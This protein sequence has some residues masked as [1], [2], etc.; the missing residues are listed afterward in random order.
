MHHFEPNYLW[1]Q[2]VSG[3]GDR[4]H[5]ISFAK[6]E[7]EKLRA[8]TTSVLARLKWDRVD[9][10][11]GE[12][13]LTPTISPPTLPT[14]SLVRWK[15]Y[16]VNYGQGVTSVSVSLYFYALVFSVIHC[17]LVFFF[18]VPL[19]GVQCSHFLSLC[20]NILYPFPLWCIVR[21][22]LLS[23]TLSLFLLPPCSSLQQPPKSWM[24]WHVSFHHPTVSE[25]RGECTD[26]RECVLR[27]KG[28][29]QP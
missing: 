9:N 25:D 8:R 2:L 26:Q 13:K 29:S 23:S 7:W 14:S 11:N 22:F 18:I 15:K 4:L 19:S 16:T 27:R 24:Y 6:S 3:S 28:P 20:T 1:A 5:Q 17:S 12:M 10:M 21:H